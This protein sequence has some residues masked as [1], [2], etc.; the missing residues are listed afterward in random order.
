MEESD[1]AEKNPDELNDRDL[2]IDRILHRIFETAHA[3][4]EEQVAERFLGVGPHGRIELIDQFS[5]LL[6]LM[7]DY[8][9]SEITALNEL[10]STIK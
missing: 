5:T 3:L 4:E 8:V 6:G 1:V 10:H 7:K 2:K 9:D